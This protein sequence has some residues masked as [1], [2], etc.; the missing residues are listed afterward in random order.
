MLCAACD[1]PAARKVCGFVGHGSTRGCSRCL[2]KFST[3][4]FKQKPDYSNFNRESWK[5]RT[6]SNHRELCEKYLLCNTRAGQIEIERKYGIRFSC[7]VKLPYFDCSRMCIVDPM[8]NLLLGTAKRL[9]NIWMALEILDVKKLISVQ[10]A[11]D[12]FTTPIDIGRVPLKIASKFSGFTAEQWK[13][14]VLYFSL[15][16]LKPL[17][18]AVH[19]DYWHKFVRACYIFCRRNISEE[20]VNIGDMTIMNFCECFLS[21]YGKSLL[22]PNIHLHGHLASFIKDFGPVYSFWLFPYERL[23]GILGSYHSNSHNISAQSMTRFLDHDLYSTYKWPEEMCDTFYPL[24][25]K[26]IYN[27]G[28]LQQR[29][30]ETTSTTSI[31]P[32]SPLFEDALASDEWEIVSTLVASIPVRGKVLLLHEVAKAIKLNDFVIGSSHSRV[33]KASLI[34]AELQCSNEYLCEVEK[35]IGVTVLSNNNDNRTVWLA[36]VSVYML[37]EQRDYF[38][39]PVQVWSMTQHSSYTYIKVESIKYRVVATKMSIDF[40]NSVQETVYVTIPLEHK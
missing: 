16:V 29:G 19:Y 14:W 12:G 30:F 22:T 21:L 18:P 25:E 35:F 26:C 20:Q 28:S 7:L 5:L 23:N 11:V 32:I 1:V 31:C 40:P 3:T 34:Y 6:K 15:P 38:G 4:E 27:K 24:I 13:S 8:H 10:E 9:M 39:Y 36:V 33:T 2:A 17:L 37:H